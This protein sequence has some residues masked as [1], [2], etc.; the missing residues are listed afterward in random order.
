MLLNNGKYYMLNGGINPSGYLNEYNAKSNTIS[1]SEG[2][3]SCGY[4]NY[5]IEPFWSGGHCYTLIDE[6]INN[7]YLFYLLKYNQNNIMKL[8]VGS[9]LP[10]IQK[11]DLENFEIHVHAKDNHKNIAKIFKTFD[12]KIKAVEN[13][14]SYLNKFK[15]SMLQKLFI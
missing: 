13:K 5:N 10:N 3:N 7:E 9:G 6:K 2:G 12:F 14:L 15:K 8:R 4:I 1:I 11:S